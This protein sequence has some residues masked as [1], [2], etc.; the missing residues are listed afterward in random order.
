[1]IFIFTRLI[2]CNDLA[3]SGLSHF[4]N[5]RWGEHCKLA[6]LQGRL[7]FKELDP[8]SIPEFL[9]KLGVIANLF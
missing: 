2:N 3:L 4:F 7:A 6:S 5:P 9:L 1:M 8:F